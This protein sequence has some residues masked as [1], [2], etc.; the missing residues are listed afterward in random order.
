[1][2]AIANSHGSGGEEERALLGRELQVKAA[3]GP[4]IIDSAEP[5]PPYAKGEAGALEV[6]NAEAT[7]LDRPTDAPPVDVAIA[8]IGLGAA[9]PKESSFNL[10]QEF[11]GLLWRRKHKELMYGD[12]AQDSLDEG[13]AAGF[14]HEPSLP[15][16]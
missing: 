11:D 3:P 10:L 16:G 7:E 8:T 9:S 14:V 2:L 4:A 13:K 15:E 12:R 1:M 5:L 6:V